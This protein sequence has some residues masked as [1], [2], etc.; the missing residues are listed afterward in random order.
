MKKNAAF[1]LLELTIILSIIAIL[2]AGVMQASSMINASRLANARSFTVNSE[3]N[4]IEGLT[5]WYET[6]LQSSFRVGENIDDTQITEWRD[7]NPASI[8][9]DKNK[10][11]RS[12]SSGVIFVSDGINKIPSLQFDGSSKISIANFFQG[13]LQQSTIFVVAKPMTLSGTSVILDSDV[14]NS[15]NSLGIKTSAINL[16][17]GSSVDFSNTVSAGNDYIISAYFN[18]TSSTA[19]L[20]SQTIASAQD[21]GSNQLGGLT[22]GAN[23]S[24]S[25]GFFGLISEIIIFNRPLKIQERVE[26]LNY[27]SK[28]YRINIS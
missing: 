13:N 8:P 15:T 9:E 6:S 7:N 23:K 25:S 24:T 3:I 4:K 10:L 2:S 18:G 28:K 19:S 17:A 26:V 21:S 20:N 12:A 14:S 1:S 22:L 27:L 11:T 5:A 16:N